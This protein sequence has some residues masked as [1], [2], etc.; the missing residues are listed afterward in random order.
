MLNVT[1][2]YFIT[3]IIFRKKVIIMNYYGSLCTEMY[4]ILHKNPPQDELKFYLS[5]AK[6]NENILEALCGS[7]RFLV[8][9]LKKGFDIKG[10]DNS[11][12]MIS[13]LKQKSPNAKIIQSNIEHYQTDEKFDYIFITSGSVSLFTDMKLC[14]NILQKMKNLLKTNGKFIFAVD[15]IANCCEDDTV[16][17]V[18][19]KENYDL[20]LKTKNHYDAQTHT[21]F[22]PGIYKLYDG[23]N[24]LQSEQMDF[25]T[26]L[27]EFG[28]MENILRQIH[29]NK[30][31]VYSDFDK[32]IAI[33]NQ[34]KMFL[35][36]CIF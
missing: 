16:L 36:E 34:A 20:I 9:F 14:Q 10:I 12:E 35:Y 5:Y 8:P 4:E 31:T 1:K 19:T 2:N 29:F 21:Q 3:N 7:G 15:T 30:I 17:A 13:K 26:H 11:A 25:Q 18:K 6:K 28:E 22:S 24:L 32:S 27:Y 33:N 23:K